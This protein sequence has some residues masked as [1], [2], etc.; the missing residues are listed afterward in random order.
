MRMRAHFILLTVFSLF[1][2][3]FLVQGCKCPEPDLIDTLCHAS[4]VIHAK[5]IDKFN[6]GGGNYAYKTNIIESFKDVDISDSLV[7]T[8]SSNDC[9][10]EIEVGKEYLITGQQ[11]PNGQ[12][13]V[14]KCD[15]AVEWSYMRPQERAKIRERK[16]PNCRASMCQEN[17]AFLPS[18]YCK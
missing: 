10:V 9:G 8:S 1:P 17:A 13:S 14:T 4:Y 18:S 12:L 16:Y 15:V 2:S 7:T 5:V 3:I 6:E 11:K